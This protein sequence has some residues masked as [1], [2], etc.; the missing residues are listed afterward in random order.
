MTVF[1]GISVFLGVF[2]G[3]LFVNL[4]L[5]DL[6]KQDRSDQLKELE[7]ELRNQMREHARRVTQQNELNSIDISA[8][9]HKHFSILE[10]IKSFNKMITQ[11]GLKTD[12]QLIGF[13]GLTGGAVV[14]LGLY[15]LLGSAL[16]GVVAI[17]AGAIMPII[18]IFSKRKQRMNQLSEQLPDAL[19]LMARVL[20]SGQTITQAMNGVADEFSDP[21]G[22]E[23]GFCYE[24][25]NL[26]LSL[27]VAMKN[28]V[29]RTGL[30]E[31]KILVM[32][33]NIQ[34]QAG[35][36]LAELLDNLSE[37][38]RQRQNLKGTVKTLTA[39]GRMQAAVL[40]GLPFFIWICMLF[41]NRPYALKL[42]EHPPLIYGTLALMGIGTVWIRKIVNIEY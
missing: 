24:Q 18:Y 26:G 37:V 30:I 3:I 27:D 15:F 36:N 29:E 32:G 12:P 21:V 34:R 16:L 41:V 1:L 23:F 2:L 4:I 19:E 38:M 28:M 8:G 39:E 5:T 31:I 10:L 35:G 6:F 33:V 40:L 7:A 9:S 42:L 25:Q 17:L 11:A 22:T 20:R 14:G 13:I